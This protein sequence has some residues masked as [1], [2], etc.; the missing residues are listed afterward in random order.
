MKGYLTVC[1][2]EL[3]PDPI[4]DSLFVTRITRQ[5]RNEGLV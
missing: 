3:N 1:I 5:Y 2:K 4:L